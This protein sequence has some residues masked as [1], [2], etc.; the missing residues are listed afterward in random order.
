[1]S[2]GSL[3]PLL[4]CLTSSATVAIYGEPIWNPPN[5]VLK[6]LSTSYSSSSRAAAFFAGVGLVVCQLAINTV[7]NSFSTGMDLAGLFPKYINIRR[8]AYIGLVLSIAMCP[9]ELLSSAGTFINVMSAY[10]VFLGPMCGI[11]ICHYW[12]I[13]NRRIKLSDLY[14]PHSLGIYYY[15]K[16]LNYRSFLAWIVGWVT[17]IPG[18]L[19]A[20]NPK[21]P[22]EDGLQKMYYLAF[23]L[24]FA[25]S[26]VVYYGLNKLDPP[27]GLGLVD[28]VDYFGTFTPEE[29]RKLGLRSAEI[30]EGVDG[31]DGVEVVVVDSKNGDSGRKT[32][33][34]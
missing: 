25:I 19:N 23:P 27:T 20:V 22:A 26:A 34:S 8:G 17:Q 4:G 11:Q 10:S 29:A 21:I 14:D 7:D 16:G 3:L 5:I 1:M 30:L 15:W 24:G 32:F 12:L 2:F 9:W 13:C 18:F 6:W 28:E 33:D 31:V